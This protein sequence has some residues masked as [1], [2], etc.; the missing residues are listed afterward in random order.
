[1]ENLKKF[2]KNKKILITGATGFLGYHLCKSLIEKNIKFT[3][4]DI[5]PM[6]KSILISKKVTYYKK[7]IMN[8]K[9]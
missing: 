1:M 6:H 8:D 2:Y 9:F 3:A 4:V 7:S 5:K